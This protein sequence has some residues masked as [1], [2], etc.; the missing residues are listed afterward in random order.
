[1]LFNMSFSCK[2]RREVKLNVE[3]DG[4]KVGSESRVICLGNKIKLD[5]NGGL[6]EFGPLPLVCIL[7]SY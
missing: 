3:V 4:F 2:H 6:P 5:L 7:L 1:M